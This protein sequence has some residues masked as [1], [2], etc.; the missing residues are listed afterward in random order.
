M[1]PRI[2]R[3]L[4]A[5]SLLLTACQG[6]QVLPGDGAGWDG[7]YSCHVK[8]VDDI[9]LPDYEVRECE[10]KLY[11]RTDNRL[12]D[13]RRLHLPRGTTFDF[14]I[15]EPALRK[16][17][18][19]EL[20]VRLAVP[21][22]HL[23]FSTGKCWERA[24]LSADGVLQLPYELRT[25]QV[26]PRYTLIHGRMLFSDGAPIAHQPVALRPPLPVQSR[27]VI[28]TATDAQGY[29]AAMAPWGEPHDPDSGYDPG[30]Q[31]LWEGGSL[32][33]PGAALWAR[34]RRSASSTGLRFRSQHGHRAGPC[35]ATAC[36][37]G[38]SC[39]SPSTNRCT[40]IRKPKC[41]AAACGV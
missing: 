18:R 40:R 26:D 36:F 39:G 41:V 30:P 34:A 31:S 5:L 23:Q 10:L 24:Q 13:A 38:A 17:V 28:R 1:R 20:T 9:G 33:A 6:A 37:R 27:P 7:R 4:F 19:G 35:W 8:I 29:F 14:S 21:G 15:R 16:N 11:D 32:T 12:L 2:P 3:L 22:H 25:S